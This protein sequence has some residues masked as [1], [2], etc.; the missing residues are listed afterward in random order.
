[1]ELPLAL[2]LPHRGAR[3]VAPKIPWAQRVGPAEKPA[4]AQMAFSQLDCE[5]VAV[6]RK[7]LVGRFL[8]FILSFQSIISSLVFI[9]WISLLGLVRYP[10]PWFGCY[11]NVKVRRFKEVKIKIR[12][13]GLPTPFNG[14]HEFFQFLP[15]LHLHT[16]PAKFKFFADKDSTHSFGDFKRLASHGGIS[17][18]AQLVLCSSKISRQFL[19][20]SIVVIANYSSCFMSL[21]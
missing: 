21:L 20:N 2:G 11:S 13:S 16:L 3:V 18:Q 4:I 12:A 17:R 14:I 19:M 1:V 8:S 15:F 5:G 7:I 9:P 10:C 6:Q